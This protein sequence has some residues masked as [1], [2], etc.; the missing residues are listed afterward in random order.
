MLWDQ[1]TGRTRIAF[2]SGESSLSRDCGIAIREQR[3]SAA[4]TE[5]QREVVKETEW[6]DQS[7]DFIWT[8]V[9]LLPRWRVRIRRRRRE[10]TKRV[11]PGHWRGSFFFFL[12]ESIGGSHHGCPT[13]AW[14]SRVFAHGESQR[15]T[16][17]PRTVYRSSL[18]L[19]LLYHA[20]PLITVSSWQNAVHPLKQDVSCHLIKRHLAWLLLPFTTIYQFEIFR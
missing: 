2:H 16:V 3:L 14:I 8:E 9:S 6:E 7:K 18:F 5:K 1:R 11:H 13:H 20:F 10:I 19:P 12:Q 15:G 17:F 4:L